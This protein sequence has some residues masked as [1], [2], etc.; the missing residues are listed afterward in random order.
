MGEATRLLDVDTKWMKEFGVLAAKDGL[1]L[2]QYYRM[3]NQSEDKIYKV[4][5]PGAA[6]A[7]KLLD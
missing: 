3:E 7:K 5:E 1:T 2:E 6:M 4:R